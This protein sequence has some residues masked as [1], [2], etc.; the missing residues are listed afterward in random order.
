MATRA[1]RLFAATGGS[2][3]LPPTSIPNGNKATKF[4]TAIRNVAVI[5]GTQQSC[6]W[7][8]GEA[9]IP[10]IGTK[11]ALN[12]HVLG[13]ELEAGGHCNAAQTRLLDT[14]QPAYQLLSGNGTVT[15]HRTDDDATCE[16]VR[17]FTYL[18]F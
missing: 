5:N 15:M 17:N 13:C 9:S 7:A 16:T 12:S 4:Y 2:Y 14:S 1:S 3:S 8:T 6:D 11:L 18:S 10:K